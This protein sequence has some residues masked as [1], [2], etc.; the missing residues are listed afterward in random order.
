MAGDAF[1]PPG[2]PV[3]RDSHAESRGTGVLVQARPA[4]SRGQRRVGGLPLSGAWVG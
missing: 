2:F 1:T 3:V 4:H